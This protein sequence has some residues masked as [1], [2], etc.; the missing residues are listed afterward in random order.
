MGSFEKYHAFVSKWEGGLSDNKKDPGGITKYGVSLRFLKGLGLALGDLDHDGDVDADDIRN[1]TPEQSRAIFRREFFNRYSIADYPAPVG[2]ALYD[3]MVNMGPVQA[4]KCLQ[5]ALNF[6][7]GMTLLVDGVIGNNT[8]KA[9]AS[10]CVTEATTMNV[11][12]RAV[13]QRQKFYHC[14]VKKNP[15]LDR[16]LLGWLNRTNALTK[17]IQEM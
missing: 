5:Y 10:K 15:D 3:A 7:P 9:L 16:F 8:K 4:G 6:Y 2:M 14:L 1:M 13:A 17:Y 12:L 11:A